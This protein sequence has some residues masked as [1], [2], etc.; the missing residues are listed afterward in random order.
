MVGRR[1]Q[2]R[3]I[4]LRI[5]P[6]LVRPGNLYSNQLQSQMSLSLFWGTVCKPHELLE[7]PGDI[8]TMP[9]KNIPQSIAEISYIREGRAASGK[10]GKGLINLQIS[11]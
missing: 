7:V 1:H 6:F 11:D 5:R 2:C 3:N 9:L 4:D 10:K 8:K